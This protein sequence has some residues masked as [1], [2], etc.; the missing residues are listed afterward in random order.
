MTSE[1]HTDPQTRSVDRPAHGGPTMVMLLALAIPCALTFAAGA[2][3][4]QETGETGLDANAKLIAQIEGPR[5]PGGE[6]DSSRTLQQLMSDHATPALSLAIVKDYRVLWAKA[7]GKLSD[8]GAANANVET[9]FQAASISKPVSAMAVLK[10]VQAGRFGLDDD[11]NTLLRSW[12]LVESKEFLEET[13][14]TPRMLLSMTAGTTVSGFPGY[15]PKDKIPTVVQVLGAKDGNGSRPANTEPVIVGWEP[16]TKT[17]YSGGGSTVLQLALSD[18]LEKPFEVILQETVLTPLN[19]TKSCFC[20]PLPTELHHNAARSHGSRVNRDQSQGQGNAPWHVYPELYAAG[21]WTTAT[22][23][24]KF[25]IEVQLSLDGR[26]NKI[27]DQS[28]VQKMVT[29]GG[30]GNYAL[31]FTAGLSSPHLPAQ[32]G[33]ANRLFGH[34]GGNW[35]FRTNLEAHLKGGNGFVILSNSDDANPIIFYELPARIRKAYGWAN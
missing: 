8:G 35:G 20:Q 16:N 29:P 34:T 6:G 22:D 28:M 3:G 17:E 4:A 30:L 26:S 25:M 2:A 33:E 15:A 12:K 14:V 32:P 5:V 18:V 9:L 7:Y 21:L 10:A 11:I 31:G 24:A 27:L 19:M 1:V 23:L 13:S